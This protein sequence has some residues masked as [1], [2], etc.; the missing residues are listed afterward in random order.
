MKLIL[1]F[2]AGSLLGDAF[3]HLL[4]EVIEYSNWPYGVLIGYMFGV[5]VQK[6]ALVDEDVH[7]QGAY[8]NLLA[9]CLDNFTHG[10]AIGGSF[11]IDSTTGLTTTASI[12]IHEVNHNPYNSNND[13]NPFSQIPHEFGD[14]AILIRGGLSIKRAAILQFI[15]AVAGETYLKYDI[16]LKVTFK[17]SSGS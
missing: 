14:F 9:N 3:L 15:T 10:L 7:V 16:F 6:L 17:G 12:L 13:S 11:M 2:G 5:L 4:P 8:I 1:A